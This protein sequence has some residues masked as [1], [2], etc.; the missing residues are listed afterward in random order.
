M[1]LIDA[2][3]ICLHYGGLAKI[4]PFDFQAIAEYFYEQIKAQPTIAPPPND[5]LTLDE[6]REMPGEPVWCEEYQC[7]GIVKC[8][9]IGRWAGKPFLVGA[10]YDTVYKVAVNFEYDIKKRNL[11]LYRYKP[12]DK[13]SGDVYERS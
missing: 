4:G 2:D 11:T 7:W 8:E 5:P 13:D 12:E 6:L 10:S 1:R 9:G 3:K